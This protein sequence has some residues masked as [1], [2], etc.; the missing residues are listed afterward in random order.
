MTQ[1]QINKI[2]ALGADWKRNP[3]FKELC[4]RTWNPNFFASCENKI[5]EIE[6]I[7]AIEQKHLYKKEVVD[8]LDISE[9]DVS[10]A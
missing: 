9:I 10:N 7:E 3:S 8:F 2:K 5:A 1:E 6:K 4:K